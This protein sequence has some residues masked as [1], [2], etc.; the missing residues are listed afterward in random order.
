MVI[1]TNPLFEGG[2][3]GVSVVSNRGLRDVEARFQ[4]QGKRSSKNIRNNIGKT[5]LWVIASSEIS[6]WV[7]R[8]DKGS[9][10]RKAA[11][12]QH[13]S[14]PCQ[15]LHIFWS[16]LLIIISE[17]ALSYK[18]S[19]SPY[20][21]WVF[22]ISI[23]HNLTLAMAVFLATS[24]ATPL[25]PA[26]PKLQDSSIELFFRKTGGSF[27][28]LP[29]QCPWGDSVPRIDCYSPMAPRNSSPLASGTRLSRGVPWVA[30]SKTRHC[31]VW[32]WRPPT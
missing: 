23:L 25:N 32:S 28:Q 24:T 17:S 3:R 9:S 20:L 29:V 13:P 5:K 22:Y 4:N 6:F 31:G 16:H 18:L 8:D 30:A 1:S 15:T 2:L 12:W 21:G 14:G 27:S 10:R 19:I 26:H 7:N 11:C